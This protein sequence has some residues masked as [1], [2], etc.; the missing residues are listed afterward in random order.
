MIH[1][2]IFIDGEVGTT[3]LEIRERLE[4]R[5]LFLLPLGE[6]APEGR[7]RVGRRLS[8]SAV[9]RSGRRLAPT[10]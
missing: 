5:L 8:A 1:T 3:G 6:G 9:A 7:M 2:P 4:A 10:D